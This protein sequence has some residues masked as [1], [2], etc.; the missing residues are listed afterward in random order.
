MGNQNGNFSGKVAPPECVTSHADHEVS[1]LWLLVLPCFRPTNVT[2]K[3]TTQLSKKDQQTR[4]H[5][6]Y[7][8]GNGAGK[9]TYG[10]N[11]FAHRSKVLT[12]VSSSVCQK[13]TKSEEARKNKQ[14]LLNVD[15][16]RL[17]QVWRFVRTVCTCT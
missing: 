17:A 9:Q 10:K 6:T 11:V 12:F 5:C 15:A 3:S 1:G 7:Y 4:N 8:G 13:R 16:D 2:S 14:T